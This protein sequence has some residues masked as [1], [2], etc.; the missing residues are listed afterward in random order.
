MLSKAETEPRAQ[1]QPERQSERGWQGG[2][3]LQSSCRGASTETAPEVGVGG[4]AR[5]ICTLPEH[6][7]RRGGGGAILHVQD[8]F[9][10]ATRAGRRPVA[11]G[12][13][14]GL[15]FDGRS[16][17]GTEGPARRETRGAMTGVEGLGEREEAGAG[18]QLKREEGTVPP[19]GT[20]QASP[21]DRDGSSARSS[22]TDPKRG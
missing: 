10:Q 15:G 9:G 13:R 22:T 5:M 19:S 18:V 4:E 21:R 1:L 11:G 3:G 14:D 2:R 17:Y 7:Q 6:V 20:S 12:T 8:E 16:A